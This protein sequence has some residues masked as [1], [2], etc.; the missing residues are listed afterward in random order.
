MST[1]PAP[2]SGWAAYT[3][4]ATT[5]TGVFQITTSGDNTTVALP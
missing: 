3:L 1:V 4:N 5:A 2:P